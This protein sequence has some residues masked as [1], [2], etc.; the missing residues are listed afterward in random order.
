MIQIIIAISTFIIG[1]TLGSFYTL[2]VYRIPLNKDITHERSFCPNCNHRLEFLDL[3]PILSYIFLGGKCR[4]CG[5]KIRPRYLIIEIISGIVFMLFVLSLNID[6]YNIRL[7]DII[8][9]F[10][11][12]IYLSILVITIGI[13]LERKEINKKMLIF[14]GI[15]SVI[16]ILYLYVLWN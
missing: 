11:G 16:Y 9:I 3:I 15:V 8:N 6:Y 13:Y 7:E 2:A 10:F 14:T 1:A 4:Y 12:M 5:Q